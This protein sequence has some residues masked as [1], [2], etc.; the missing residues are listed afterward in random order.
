MASMKPG[1]AEPFIGRHDALTI[2]SWLYQVDTYLKRVAL[3]N[4]QLMP[5]ESAKI[6]FANALLE[7]NAEN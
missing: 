5:D 1:K 7:G 6:A 4:P 3:A 2:N